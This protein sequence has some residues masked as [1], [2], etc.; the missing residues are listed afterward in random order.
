MPQ[1]MRTVLLFWILLLLCAVAACAQLQKVDYA[2][3]ERLQASLSEAASRLDVASASV[4]VFSEDGITH[5]AYHG[6]GITSGSLFQ[7]ASL[8]KSVTALG[9]LLVSHERG[10]DLDEDVR[11]YITSLDWDEIKGGSLPITLRQLLSHTSGAT[12]H[13]FPGYSRFEDLPTSVEIVMGS[14]R[15]NTP[16]IRLKPK[17]GKFSYSGGGY[18]ILQLFIEDQTGQPFDKA[19][20]E[21]VLKPLKMERSSFSQPIDPMTIHPLSI[22][23]ADQQKIPLFNLFSETPDTWNNYPEQAAAGLWTTS[24]DF[25]L[26]GAALQRAQAGREVLGIPNELL[27]QLF[28]PVTEGYGLGL[29]LQQSSDGSL[30]HFGHAGANL[31][32]RCIFRSFPSRN[33]GVVVMTNSPSGE[34]L[35]MEVV[36]AFSDH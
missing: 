30:S 27:A 21:L 33:E 2:T 36:S 28:V 34:R 6:T 32:Y 9:I 25:A 29:A 22:A 15:T 31:G 7:A 26:F 4:T 3:P 12:E 24:A 18:Q 35:M 20:A 16:A 13:G 17:K 10:I 19:M 14:A 8:S 11:P 23:T 1:T 5:S